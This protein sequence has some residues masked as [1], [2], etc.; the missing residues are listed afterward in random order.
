M[1]QREA[2]TPGRGKCGPEGARLCHQGFPGVGVVA[3]TLERTHPAPHSGLH[4]LQSLPSCW[5]L[6]DFAPCPICPFIVA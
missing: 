4:A 5:A 3:L 6:A 1:L 2:A